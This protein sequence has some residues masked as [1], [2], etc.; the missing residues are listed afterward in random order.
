MTLST[1]SLVDRDTEI[2]PY[3]GIRPD[4][5]DKDDLLNMLAIHAT[6]QIEAYLDRLLV[7]RGA[8]TEYHTLREVTASL[9]LN[10]YPIVSVTSVHEDSDREYAAADLL[11]ENT[12][13]IVTKPVAKL[14]RIWGATDSERAWELGFRSV[15]VVYVGGYSNTASVPVDLKVEALRYIGHAWGE[16]SRQQFGLSSVSD[17]RGNMQRFFPGALTP[18]MKQALA[19]HRRHDF[20]RTGEVL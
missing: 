16:V 1:Y 2:K 19:R 5:T 3:L 10:Q 13:Y 15:K 4:L 20:A 11:V 7:S 18:I 14:S 8:I 9:Y 6:S 17:D 12:D